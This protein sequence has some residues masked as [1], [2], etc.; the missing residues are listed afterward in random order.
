M[1]QVKHYREESRPLIQEIEVCR[2]N[3]CGNSKAWTLFD[4]SLW[5]TFCGGFYVFEAAKHVIQSCLFRP[6]SYK[7]VGMGGPGCP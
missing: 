1:A 6:C 2:N 3:F 7:S 5:T 4:P